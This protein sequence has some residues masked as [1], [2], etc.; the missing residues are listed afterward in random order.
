MTK[1]GGFE[2]ILLTKHKSIR[3]L[4]AFDEIDGDID[5]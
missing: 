3:P 5:L 2:G 4:S 1:G